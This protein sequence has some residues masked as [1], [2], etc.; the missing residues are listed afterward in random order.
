MDLIV[1]ELRDLAHVPRWGIARLIR[2]QSVAE[3]SFFVACY[4][5][6]IGDELQLSFNG[7]ELIRWA[8]IHDV[9]ESFMSDIPGPSKRSVVDRFK[10]AHYTDAGSV[11]RFGFAPSHCQG[12]IKQIVKLADL[13][14]EVMFLSGE[15]QMG[16]QAILAPLMS[17]N[18]RMFLALKAIDCDEE[19]KTNFRIKL[20]RAT[21]QEKGGSSQ[22]PHNNEDVAR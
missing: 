14:D 9:D 8:L 13:I 6:Q 12:H 3:H 21:Q 7:D 17:A 19:L 11:K 5:M 10:Y 15:L 16:N 2:G 1:R 4:A 22:I 18:E 20:S